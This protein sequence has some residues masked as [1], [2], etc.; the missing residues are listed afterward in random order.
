MYRLFYLY[1]NY[2]LNLL[3]CCVSKLSNYKVTCMVLC[4]LDFTIAIQ[5]ANQLQ[6]VQGYQACMRVHTCIAIYSV[7]CKFIYYHGH[8]YLAC[9]H[10]AAWGLIMWPEEVQHLYNYMVEIKVFLKMEGLLASQIIIMK[11]ATY[12]IS[13]NPLSK[14]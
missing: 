3:I 4:T 1:N 8:K 2:T 13:W 12:I 6:A 11:L 7:T 9:M 14:N 5:S 10:M